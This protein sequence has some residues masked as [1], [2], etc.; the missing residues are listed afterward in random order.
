MEFSKDMVSPY[1]TIANKNDVCVFS[2]LGGYYAKSIE[3]SKYYYIKN[4]QELPSDDVSK[5]TQIDA[6]KNYTSDNVSNAQATR[7][8][9]V[10]KVSVQS[11]VS[12][13]YSDPVMLNVPLYTQRDSNS[14]APTS[15]AMALRYNWP[16]YV[17]SDK[18]S[19]VTELESTMGWDSLFGTPIAN[20]PTGIINAMHHWGLS[21]IN[22]SNCFNMLSAGRGVNTFSLAQ[23]EIDSYWPLLINAPH[24]WAGSHTMCVVGYH[25]YD[26]GEDY[27][28]CHDTFDGDGNVEYDYWSDTELGNDFIY[29]IIN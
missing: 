14:C 12:P 23:Y 7:N 16:G 25:V 18:G 11:S 26:V 29:T 4:K 21:S 17:P 15:A 8:K 27:L 19:I 13:M 2:G 22:S 10:S 1:D 28:I 24:F 6:E 5:L 3:T 9:L 20:I